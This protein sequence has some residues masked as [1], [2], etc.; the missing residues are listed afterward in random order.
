MKKQK[1]YGYF[2]CI[3]SD[4]KDYKKGKIYKLP[5]STTYGTW[6]NGYWLRVVRKKDWIK[7]EYKEF[8]KFMEEKALRE[9]LKIIENSQT[10]WWEEILTTV[11]NIE[12]KL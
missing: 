1:K 2:E 8:R 10:T 4:N 5:A 6:V 12:S 7:Q 11:K 3:E 9:R